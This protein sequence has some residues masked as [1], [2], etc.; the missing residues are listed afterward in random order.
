MPLEESRPAMT[1]GSGPVIRLRTR[2]VAVGWM[3]RTLVPTGMVKRWKLMMV[4]LA[5]VMVVLRPCCWMLALPATTCPPWGCATT[6]GA[7]ERAA[8]R[9]RRG[10]QQRAAASGRRQAG[11][12]PH[13]AEDNRPALSARV[14][15]V[16]MERVR[17]ILQPPSALVSGATAAGGRPHKPL[18]A[19]AP[20]RLWG[21]GSVQDRADKVQAVVAGIGIRGLLEGEAPVE[22]EVQV[23]ADLE[24]DA[25]AGADQ[26]AVFF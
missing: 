13:R 11:R 9:P 23:A 1:E 5:A 24:L 7:M 20:P 14:R 26:G 6:L 8:V 4:L 3:K 10:N 16:T 12:L 2:L 22:P 21:S 25:D 18:M 19:G 17:V 15:A